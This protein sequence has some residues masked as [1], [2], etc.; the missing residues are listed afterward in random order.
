MLRRAVPAVTAALV[1]SVSSLARAH[2]EP[3]DEDAAERADALFA[4]GKADMAAG[5]VA[6]ACAAFDESYA[7]DPSEGTLLALGLCHERSGDVGRAFRELRDVHASALASGREDRQRVARAALARVGPRV[8]RVVIRVDGGEPAR[9]EV[10]TLD[11]APLGARDLGVEIPVEPGSHRVACARGGVAP[12]AETVVVTAGALGVVVVPAA[13]GDVPSP[14]PR[15][16]AGGARSPEPPG[17]AGDAEPGAPTLGFA[18]GGAGLVALGVGAYFGVRAFDEWATVEA[19][20]EPAACTDASARAD[21]DAA[22]TS[23]TVANVA[24]VVGAVLVAAGAYVILT[25]PRATKAAPSAGRPRAQLLPP[26]LVW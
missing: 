23:A 2:G 25:S 11:G 24:V 4:R 12:W 16:A 19:K 9:C 18:L 8:G 5:R 15:G 13:R 21:A 17:G 22:R 3:A 10:V 14:E 26:R 7:L 6:R 1:L 20:C